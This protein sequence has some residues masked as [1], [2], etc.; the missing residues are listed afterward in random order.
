MLTER[1]LRLIRAA[2]MFYDEEMSPHGTETMNAYFDPPLEEPPS[3]AEIAELR[4]RLQNCRLRYAGCNA[5][6]TQLL[7]TTLDTVV[8]PVREIAAASRGQIA[9]VLCF[10]PGP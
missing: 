6:A 9:C 7:S 4:S 8:E 5:E 10:P 2:L 3:A 1:N